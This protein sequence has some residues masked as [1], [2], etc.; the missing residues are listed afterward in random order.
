MPLKKLGNEEKLVQGLGDDKISLTR[1]PD[2][3]ASTGKK[4]L[5]GN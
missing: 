1:V 4:A 5:D 3:K 2:S